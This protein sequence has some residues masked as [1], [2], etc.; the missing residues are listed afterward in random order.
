MIDDAVFDDE[1]DL[2]FRS[3]QSNRRTVKMRQ[4]IQLRQAAI[5]NSVDRHAF[6]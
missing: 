4:L 6:L 2:G 1:G 5:F 3:Y